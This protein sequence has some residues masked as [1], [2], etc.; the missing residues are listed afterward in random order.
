VESGLGEG[1]ERNIKFLC[2]FLCCD[3][4]PFISFVEHVLCRCFGMQ[5]RIILVA[6]VVGQH[7]CPALAKG[8]RKGGKVKKNFFL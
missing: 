6:S 5:K 1:E 4:W 3:A 7:M 2:I 8:G